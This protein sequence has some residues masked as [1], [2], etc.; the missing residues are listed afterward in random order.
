MSLYLHQLYHNIKIE[1]HHMEKRQ[2][3]CIFCTNFTYKTHKHFIL[4]G[5]VTAKIKITDGRT[6]TLGK[7][8]FF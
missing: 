3:K 1:I 5:T 2:V 7:Y 4:W 6:P 8:R